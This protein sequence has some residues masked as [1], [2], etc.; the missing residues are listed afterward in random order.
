MGTKLRSRLKIEPHDSKVQAAAMKKSS[1]L[2]APAPK[3][4][5]Q[6]QDGEPKIHG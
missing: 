2:K 3:P 4:I 6:A 1:K 5:R